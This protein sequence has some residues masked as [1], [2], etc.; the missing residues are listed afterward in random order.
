MTWPETESETVGLASPKIRIREKL[1][2]Q[3]ILLVL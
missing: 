1:H 2:S 3:S